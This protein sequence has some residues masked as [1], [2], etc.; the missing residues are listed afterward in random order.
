MGF[1]VVILENELD[2][3]IRLENL[4]IKRYGEDVWIPLSDISAVVIDNMKITLTARMLSVLAEN[5]I[6]TI[7]CNSEHQPMGLYAAYDS[8]SRSSKMLKFQIDRTESVDVI[9]KEI[10]KSK[11][12]NQRST[13]YRLEID[14]GEKSQDKLLK[15]IYELE[16]KDT[17]VVEAHAAKEYFKCLGGEGFNRRNDGILLNS[18]LN[19][20]YAIIRSY[21]A[22]LCVGTG[23]NTQ[24][25]L[26]HRSEY[27]RFNL[28]DDLMEPIRPFVDLYAYK[29]LENEMYFLPEHRHKLVNI[30]NHKCKYKNKSMYISNLLEDYVE[31][32]SKWY[33]EDKRQIIFPDVLDY[34]GGED[35][36]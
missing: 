26:H 15:Y 23:L 7:F 2:V 22:K 14:S 29:L 33:R 18:G 8:H 6:A 34:L 35:G 28:V 12:E 31:Q 17:D 25:G 24:I 9:W 3:S 5:N 21:I 10:V 13:L 1:R 4:V 11:I 32:L 36:L 19:Y 16:Q 20:G 27:N 30:L